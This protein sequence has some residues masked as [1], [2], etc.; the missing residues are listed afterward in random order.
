MFAVIFSLLAAGILLFIFLKP[1]SKPRETSTSTASSSVAVP[2][3]TTAVPATTT[4]KKKSFFSSFFDFSFKT[5]PATTPSGGGMF[6]VP[7]TEPVFNTQSSA[8]ATSNSAPTSVPTTYAPTQELVGIYSEKPSAESQL[9]LQFYEI[10]IPSSPLRGRLWIS[11]VVRSTSADYE[12]L[13]L[14]S[15]EYLYQSTNITGLTIKSVV[16]GQ[17]VQIGKGTSLP[18]LNEVNTLSDIILKPLQTVY[19]NTGRSP[20]GY[21]FQINKCI[22]YFEQFQDFIPELPLQCPLL[23]YYQRPAPPNEFTDACLDY[24]EAFPA[25]Q[26]LTVNYAP[27]TD[28]GHDCLEYVKK[29][30]GYQSCVSLHRRNTDFMGMEWR[31]YLN[32]TTPLWKSRREVIWLLDQEGRFISQ[33]SY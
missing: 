16:T 27:Q 33:Y 22:G 29:L 4:P 32:W 19:V 17:T 30:T 15:N 8:P 20:L 1:D 5:A 31:V 10:N 18:M 7:K 9:E 12:Y 28:Q 14:S 11:G 13:V 3:Q 23:R 6:D 21:S 24:I 26:I 25:C 2:P